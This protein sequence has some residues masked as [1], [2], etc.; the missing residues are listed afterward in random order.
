MNPRAHTEV[1]HQDFVGHA[2]QALGDGTLVADV[3][4]LAN[5][6][7]TPPGQNGLCRS[8]WPL[9]HFRSR[10]QRKGRYSACVI[11]D[12][13]NAGSVEGTVFALRADGLAT[14]A[15]NDDIAF[16]AR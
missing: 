2:Q 6:A 12:A 11:A 8:D 14:T 9:V 16:V 3:E 15:T 1:A 4:R 7:Q 13:D 5:A 10:M